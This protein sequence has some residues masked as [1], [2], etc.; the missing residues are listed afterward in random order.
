MNSKFTILI[1]DKNR[2]IREF[3]QRELEAEGYTTRMT[4]DGR[5]VVRLVE[6]EL[7]DLI[8]LDLEIPYLD[9]P[10]ILDY[11]HNNKWQ[12]PVIVYA[13]SLADMDAAAIHYPVVFIEKG[14]KTSKGLKVEIESLL[15]QCS[16]HRMSS[17]KDAPKASCGKSPC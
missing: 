17:A 1:A 13:F 3:L 14:G 8:I 4:N 9:G 7:P 16:P 2:H 12:I 11:L 5:E 15:A 10:A 6:Q